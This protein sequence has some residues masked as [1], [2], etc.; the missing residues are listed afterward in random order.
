MASDGDVPTRTITIPAVREHAGY[1][2]LTVTVPWLCL[3]CGRQRGEPYET[4]SYDGSRRLNVHG[5]KNPCGHVEPYNT[6]RAA[7]AST[8]GNEASHV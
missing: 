2:S 1:H 7:L 4:L 3:H 8:D 6:V 5:W